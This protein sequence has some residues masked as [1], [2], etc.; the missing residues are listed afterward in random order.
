M[1]GVTPAANF[2]PI[3]F[4][5]LFLVPGPG[6]VP[7]LHSDNLKQRNKLE[8]TVSWLTVFCR[9]GLLAQQLGI[10]IVF[11]KRGLQKHWTNSYSSHSYFVIHCFKG[12]ST[13]TTT[14]C[15]CCNILYM[16]WLRTE[17]CCTILKMMKRIYFFAPSLCE[18]QMSNVPLLEIHKE[19]YFQENL[20]EWWWWRNGSRD[21][22]H[23][24]HFVLDFWLR[25]HI[26]IAIEH[27]KCLMRWKIKWVHISHFYFPPI[28]GDVNNKII[29][30]FLI[31]I[32]LL[33]LYF[34]WS[35][36]GLCFWRLLLFQ[37]LVHVH[38]FYHN[39]V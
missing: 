6:S 27:R 1:S 20:L 38:Q 29:I 13:T 26:R 22:L 5:W 9:P 25:G 16:S 10:R 33:C 23:L 12:E 21:R 14:V 4:W 17:S 31:F 39:L 37:V 34:S 19:S 2:L 3:L 28:K 36:D 18:Y 35:S 32:P 7:R 8:L 15:F 30:R 24:D 11:H